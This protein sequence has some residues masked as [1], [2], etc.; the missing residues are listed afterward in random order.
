MEEKQKNA[1]SNDKIKSNKNPNVPNLRFPEFK[2]GWV[3]FKLKDYFV[4]KNGLNK[5]KDAFG[6]G[7]KII[8]YMDVNKKRYLYSNNIKGLVKLSKHEENSFQVMY[9]DLF[10]T[11]T[12]ETSEEIGL[13]AVLLDN[14]SLMV[15]SG[16]LLRARPN[17]RCLLLPEFCSYAFSNNRIRYE[18]IKK[19]SITT[20][21]L[22]SGSLLNEVINYHPIDKE[23]MKIAK[24]FF[25]LDQR[26]EAQS[27]IIKEYKSLKNAITN[28]LIFNNKKMYK[29]ICLKN[30]ATL[31]NGYAFKSESYTDNGDFNIIT[32]ANVQGNKYIDTT[33][34][35]KI[36]KIPN[37]IQPHQILKNNDILIS[38][39]GNVG[40]VSLVNTSNCL[41]N[42]RVGVLNFINEK[43][44][45]YIYQVISNKKFETT[46]ILCGQGAAQKNIGND[47]IES[48]L[49]PLSDNLEYINKIVNLLDNLDK[50]IAIEEHIINDYLSQKKYMLCNMF[51]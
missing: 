12:S 13:T 41:L 45:K 19:S 18:I 38:L 30:F 23:Q 36:N 29:H 3:K 27:K 25:T 33:Q 1:I 2:E 48:F 39:T 14:P 50:K 7:V 26:I 34:C 20:R 47:D 42:Q 28:Q 6:Q 46:M 37:D 9:G 22:T 4:F 11:R 51:I 17:N 10:F 15:F 49:I 5:E 32:I 35:N 40:R 24:L 31:K 44:K 21:A 8:N 43:F 16:F